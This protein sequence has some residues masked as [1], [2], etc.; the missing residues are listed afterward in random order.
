MIANFRTKKKREC[1]HKMTN[2]FNFFETKS[3]FFNHLIKITFPT[4]QLN[5]YEISIIHTKNT[6]Q[7]QYKYNDV[8]CVH[9]SETS[10]MLFI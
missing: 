9:Q 3:C 8:Q 6:I 2:L 5:R 10:M 1:L 4:K 7:I